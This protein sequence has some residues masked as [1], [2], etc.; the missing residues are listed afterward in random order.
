MEEF[1][2]KFFS[3]GMMSTIGV[4]LLKTIKEKIMIGR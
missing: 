4:V 3:Q 2:G 1:E